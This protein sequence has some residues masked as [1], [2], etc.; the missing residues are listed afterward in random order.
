MTANDVV[1]WSFVAPITLKDVPTYEAAV[2]GLSPALS[3][4]SQTIMYDVH[5]IA[6]RGSVMLC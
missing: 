6:A 2:P 3:D 4:S 5:C 1:E